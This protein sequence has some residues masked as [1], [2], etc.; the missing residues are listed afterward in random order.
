MKLIVEIYK[1]NDPS[2]TD[3][4]C[5]K[6]GSAELDSAVSIDEL[7]DAARLLTDGQDDCE[8]LNRMRFYRAEDG[9]EF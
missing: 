7:L 5:V 3:D 9:T 1:S 6:V 4:E 8:T 2:D